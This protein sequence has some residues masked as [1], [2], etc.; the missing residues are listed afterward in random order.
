[1]SRNL[2][3]EVGPVVDA[4]QDPALDGRSARRGVMAVVK[5][6]KGTQLTDTASP[7]TMRGESTVNRDH[8]AAEEFGQ[9]SSGTPPGV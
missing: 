7:P 8:Q 2:L 9:D 3:R 1:M 4:H 5:K 6:V